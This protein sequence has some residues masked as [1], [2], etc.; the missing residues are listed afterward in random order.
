MSVGCKLKYA[1]ML[2]V[3][4]NVAATQPPIADEFKMTVNN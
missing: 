3:E 2:C 4:V 1:F